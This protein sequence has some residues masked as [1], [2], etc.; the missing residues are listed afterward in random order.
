MNLFEL[1]CGPA[2]LLFAGI[3]DDD[4]IRRAH[5]DP[6]VVSGGPH[7][8]AGQN[9]ERGTNAEN[10]SYSSRHALEHRLTKFLLY[11]YRASIERL[12]SVSDSDI[13]AVAGGR[14]DDGL[15]RCGKLRWTLLTL[16]VRHLSGTGEKM[17]RGIESWRGGGVNNLE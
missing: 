17:A 2:R 5:F 3:A 8:R 7:W 10:R 14:L 12:R 16:V 1:D 13:M 4:E 11:R 9:P 15:R 6:C